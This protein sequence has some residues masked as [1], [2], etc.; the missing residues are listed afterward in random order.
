[1]GRSSFMSRRY[2]RRYRSTKNQGE[3]Q[4][5]ND[6]FVIRTCII[7]LM[8]ILKVQLVSDEETLAFICWLLGKER[9][10]L[11]EALIDLLPLQLERSTYEDKLTPRASFSDYAYDLNDLLSKATSNQVMKFT[12]YADLLIE[13][14]LRT[15]KYNGQSGIEKNLSALQKM[16]NLDH[17]EISL[18]AL[19]FIIASYDAPERFLEDHLNIT[20]FEGKKYLLKALDIPA[21]K[22]NNILTGRLKSVGIISVENGGRCR[23]ELEDEFQSFISIPSEKYFAKKLFKRCQ[24]STLPL[25]FY[26]IEKDEIEYMRNLLSRK[27]KTPTHILLYGPP[28]TGKSSFAMSITRDLKATAY[29]ISTDTGN[30]SLDRRAAIVAC[31]NMTNATEEAVIIVDEADNLLNTQS[32]WFHSGETQ[33]KGWLNQLLEKSDSRMIWITNKISQIDDSVLRRFA[34]CRCF[35]PFNRDQR[36]TLWSN[37]VRQNRVKRFFTHKDLSRLSGRY[38]V[39]AGVIDLAV[40]KAKDISQGSSLSMH[41]AIKLSI[42]SYE[43]VVNGGK[44][45]TVTKKMDGAYSID[46]LNVTDNLQDVIDQLKK[47]DQ[48]IRSPN[49]DIH[50]T[51]NLLFYGPPGTGKSAL[52][53]YISKELD[54]KSLLKRASDLIHPYVGETEASISKA[55]QEAELD[56]AVLIIDEADTFLYSRESAMRSW[57]VSLVNEFL[58]QMECFEG[59]LICTTNRFDNLDQ[60]TIR[61]FPHKI[62]FDYLTPKGNIIFYK[63]ILSP[64]IQKPLS[65]TEEKVLMKIKKLAPGDFKAIRL[66]YAFYPKDELCH[67]RFI[68]GLKAES[69]I[70]LARSGD[71]RIG[72]N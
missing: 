45:K 8:K 64:L 2:R 3:Y 52:A 18:C 27:T 59:I 34:Y 44:T 47:Y 5:L 24:G 15:V 49:K 43:T 46:G 56:G 62:E 65:V 22:L 28:G 12:G 29:T 20:S 70:K 60:A 14:H 67:D 31:M 35:K 53:R 17:L 32:F 58:A 39:A 9:T 1:M 19:L 63:K 6:K 30:K 4:D 11:G 61:R 66:K 68:L 23:L 13:Q 26:L 57:E 21:Y 16:F 38:N 55:F 40:K 72:F 33:D 54:R 7:Y 37:I 36:T 25:K 50:L 10:K 48:C 42:E 69:D 41:R 71:T 51:M